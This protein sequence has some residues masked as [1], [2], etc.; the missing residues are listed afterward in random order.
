M[1][2]SVDKNLE[3]AYIY[4]HISQITGLIQR[5]HNTLHFILCVDIDKKINVWF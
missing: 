3:Y 4:Q 1:N 5:S 2:M